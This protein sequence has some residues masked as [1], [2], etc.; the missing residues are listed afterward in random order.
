MDENCDFMI[1]MFYK[2]SLKGISRKLVFFVSPTQWKNRCK[3]IWIFSSPQVDV[4]KEK[5]TYIWKQHIS[6]ILLHGWR[7]FTSYHLCKHPFIWDFL[8]SFQADRNDGTPAAPC[9]RNDSNPITDPWED[10]IFTDPW[11]IDYIGLYAEYR[12][13]YLKISYMGSYGNPN[14][15]NFNASLDLENEQ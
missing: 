9:G 13:I 10:C 8:L 7:S 12:Y 2:T 6:R 3:S 15:V 4:E 1:S 14:W 11:M 5:N